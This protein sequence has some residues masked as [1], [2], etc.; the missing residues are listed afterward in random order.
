MTSKVKS[1]MG[2]KLLGAVQPAKDDNKKPA[3][4]TSSGSLKSNKDLLGKLKQGVK[5]PK[6]SAHGIVVPVPPKPKSPLPPKK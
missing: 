6:V 4:K 5:P 3:S 1:V 2:N